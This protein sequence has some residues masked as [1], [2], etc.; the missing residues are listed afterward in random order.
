MRLQSTPI[1]ALP[2]LERHSAEL[3]VLQRA[4]ATV[5]RT[6][7]LGAVLEGCLDLAGE[8]MGAEISTIYLLD[9]VSQTLE[10]AA[11]RNLPPEVAGV[12]SSLPR[13]VVER[14][15]ARAGAPLVLDPRTYPDER[16]R[17]A[18]IAAGLLTTVSVPLLS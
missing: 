18:A 4:V 3:R 14:V 16:I 11:H 12:S 7:D 8:L 1:A 6:L 10:L 5:G 9:M 17:S 13:E 2:E 15:R